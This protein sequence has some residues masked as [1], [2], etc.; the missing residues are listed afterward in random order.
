M[1]GQHEGSGL[2]LFADGS[3]YNGEW[4]QGQYHGMEQLAADLCLMRWRQYCSAQ[5]LPFQVMENVRGVTV[6][7]MLD[8]GTWDKLMDEERKPIPTELFGM[9]VNGPLICR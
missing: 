5:L 2:Y 1:D 7:S 8:H 4:K 9:T 6:E 3:V